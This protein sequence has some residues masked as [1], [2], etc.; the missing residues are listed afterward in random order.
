VS[1]G[2]YNRQT[3][4]LMLWEFCFS[5]TYRIFA[6]RNPSGLM[7]M[8]CTLR[9]HILSATAHLGL[10]VFRGAASLGSDV[11]RLHVMS[12]KIKCICQ[13]RFRLHTTEFRYSKQKSGPRRIS[14]ADTGSLRLERL[15]LMHISSIFLRA[16]AMRARLTTVHPDSIF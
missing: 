6:R 12:Q 15:C 8:P 10:G 16:N 5:I 11:K 3:R 14:K 4:E 1:K 2:S 9:V 7:K 13:S